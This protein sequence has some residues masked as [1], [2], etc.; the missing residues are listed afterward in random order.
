MG[1][2]ENCFCFE[3]LVIWIFIWSFFVEFKFKKV[4]FERDSFRFDAGIGILGI[5][6]ILV[7]VDGYI[8]YFKFYRRI[9]I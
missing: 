5:L 7:N 8:F 3:F 9:Y 2:R 1:S 6:V 4:L